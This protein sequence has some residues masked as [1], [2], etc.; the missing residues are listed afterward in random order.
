MAFYSEAYHESIRKSPYS[1]GD[2]IVLHWERQTPPDKRFEGCKRYSTDG[3]NRNLNKNDLFSLM[4][5][6][7][8][9]LNKVFS[10]LKNDVSADCLES[11]GVYALLQGETVPDGLYYFDRESGE[12]VALPF[13]SAKEKKTTIANLQNAFPKNEF[14]QNASITLFLTGILDRAVWR[15]KEAAYHEV[16]LDVGSYAGLVSILARSVGGI[17]IPLG[18]FVDD[19]VAVA[20][21]LPSTEVPLAALAIMP[22][23]L[24]KYEMATDFAYSNR[25]EFPAFAESSSAGENAPLRRMASRFLQQNRAEC[26]TDLDHCI[27]VCRVVNQPFAGEEFP[28]TPLKFPNEYF[29]KEYSF[30]G[31]GALSNRSFQH[32]QA[33]LDDFSTILRWMEICNL[34][35]FGAGLLK[36]WVVA[37]DVLLVYPG[38][39][40][41]LPLKKSLFLHSG[42]IDMKKFCKCHL[43]SESPEGAAF[44]VIFTADVKEACNMLGE[45]AYRYLN[46]NA[47]FVAEMLRESARGLGKFARREMLYCEEELKKSCKFPEN[48]S[49]LCEVLVGK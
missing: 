8:T 14:I 7:S 37:F 41:Y 43:A 36:I 35:A 24:K 10:Q 39:Y 31:P 30:L 17:A 34:N 44:A 28:L 3:G 29:F 46:M 5:S 12:L 15:F 16:Q 33:S 25:S 47:G 1:K 19:D 18:A 32:W 4:A 42:S 27:K 40:R 22:K 2:P 26:I 48:E 20:L 38:L 23:A 6:S 11:V 9:L 21:N 49:I 13:E 45:R